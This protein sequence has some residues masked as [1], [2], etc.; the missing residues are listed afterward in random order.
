M[1]E[2][3]ECLTFP[4]SW[5]EDFFPSWTEGW[6]FDSQCQPLYQ[7][8]FLL[9]HINY[10]VIKCQL[11]S[12]H[13]YIWCWRLKK[14][15]WVGKSVGLGLGLGLGLAQLLSNGENKH[16]SDLSTIGIVNLQEKQP[17][18]SRTIGSSSLYVHHPS[19]SN[20]VRLGSVR[21][22]SGKNTKVCLS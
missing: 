19:H 4:P 11:L 15:P 5:T 12:C 9:L 2:W 20:R 7:F 6:W 17:F 13:I 18:Q 10:S 1:V 22:G 8:G 3:L 14:T 16:Y 21:L